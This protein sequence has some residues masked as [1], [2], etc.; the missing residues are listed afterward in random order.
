MSDTK[1]LR[2]V[3]KME[4]ELPEEAFTGKAVAR[5]EP[6]P[7]LSPITKLAPPRPPRRP[8]RPKRQKREHEAPQLS[9]AEML[10]IFRT[11]YLSRRLDDKEIQMKGQNRIF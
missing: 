9:R 10:K 2:L 5:A 6:R 3:K 1:V 7:A 11:M 8:K 4:G